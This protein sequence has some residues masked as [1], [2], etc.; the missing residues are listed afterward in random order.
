MHATVRYDRPIGK[1]IDR[2]PRTM[3]ERREMCQRDLPGKLLWI[4]STSNVAQGV[5]D[6]ELEAKVRE[7]D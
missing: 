7:V 1:L 3:N 4:L 6:R 2:C 5:C